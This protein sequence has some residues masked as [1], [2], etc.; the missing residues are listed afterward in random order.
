M[1]AIY[2]DGTDTDSYNFEYVIRNDGDYMY[3]T[4]IWTGTHH[5]IYSGGKE[6]EVTVSPTRLVFFWGGYT[7]TRK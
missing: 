1:S 4:L 7:Y 5:L 3:L 2:E 6:Y